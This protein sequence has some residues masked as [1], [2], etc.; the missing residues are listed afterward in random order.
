MLAPLLQSD[1][2][3]RMVFHDAK[4]AQALVASLGCLILIL[5][6]GS[7]GETTQDVRDEGSRDSGVVEN[8]SAVGPDGT[9]CTDTN[10]VNS[11]S[12]FVTS[13]QQLEELSGSPNGFGGDLRYGGAASGLAGAD[14]ICQE[15]ARR[16]CFGHRTWRAYL[17]TSRVDAIDRIGPGPWYDH[18]G[19]V[20]A[21]D[22]AGLVSL[23]RPAGGA[24]DD[25]TYDEL[26]I[27]HD[28]HSDINNDGIDDD[29]HDVMTATL[30]DGTYAGFS[31]DDWTSVTARDSG[32]DDQ[33][34]TG[35]VMGHSWVAS[36]GEPWSAAHAGHR[37]AA[38]TNFIQ[39]GPGDA[40]T[41]GGGG[42]Y[43]GIYCFALPSDD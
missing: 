14:S 38:G 25:G 3:L 23:V 35:I 27:F 11:F 15:L 31:C 17:S 40:S 21:N 43:G 1:T 33:V 30:I 20:V 16:V 5:G 42:G 41:V 24:M 34:F 22:V 7:D 12:F 10:A 2:L 9:M 4:E 37:C 36:S 18:A 6:C 19:L 32:S 26:G 8:P 29:D 13:W 28:G 39:D